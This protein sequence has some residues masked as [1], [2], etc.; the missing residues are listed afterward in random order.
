MNWLLLLY[1]ASLTYLAGVTMWL[2]RACNLCARR[3]ASPWKES[4]DRHDWA[5][6]AVCKENSNG[7]DVLLDA[8]TV[9]NPMQWVKKWNWQPPCTG[10]W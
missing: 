1:L 3:V 9:L 6:C 4:I 5:A 2:W 8:S 7:A 10:Q